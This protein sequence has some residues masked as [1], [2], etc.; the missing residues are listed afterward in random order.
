MTADLKAVTPKDDGTPHAAS[1]TD[2]VFGF[3]A[4]TDHVYAQAKVRM[5][6]PWGALGSALARAALATPWFVRL[7]PIIGDD[8]SLNALMVGVG[9][10]GVGKGVSKAEMFVWPESDPFK[11]EG[12]E[13]RLAD[14]FHPF[15]PAS[16]EGISALFKESRT[17]KVDGRTFTEQQFIRRAAW[18]DFP[19]VDQLSAVSSRQGATLSAELRK[20]WSGE[21]LGTMTKVKANQLMVA[22][23]AY[24]AVVTVS[25]QP[26]RCGPLLAEEA[27]GLLQRVLWLSADDPDLEDRDETPTTMPL[28]LPKFTSGMAAPGGEPAP[29]YF[30]VAQGVRDEIRANRLEGKWKGTEDAHRNLVRLKVAG[31]GAVLHGSSEI[32]LDLWAWAG[33]IME[34]STR[35]RASVRAE[36]GRA[37]GERRKR[38]AS[39]QAT[40]GIVAASARE[41]AVVRVAKAIEK[42]MRRNYTTAPTANQLKA[43]AVSGADRSLVDDALLLLMEND[44][45]AQAGESRVKTPL[46]GL[47]SL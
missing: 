30:T 31:A 13:Q 38:E 41:L 26:L 32:S 22:A 12:G 29:C 3:S 33:Q 14:A 24:R 17:F 10:S 40:H 16:G 7:P 11:L 25:A 45:V 18:I 20:V 1:I 35:V 39:A 44:K 2:A 27:G 19:E 43:Q 46:Y 8:A 23:H 36:L 37:E 15:T 21:P 28:T 4:L 5:I 47:V 6:S 34:H 9:P 42:W